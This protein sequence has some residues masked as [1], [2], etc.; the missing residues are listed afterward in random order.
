MGRDN[1]RDR[2]KVCICVK[3]LNEREVMLKMKK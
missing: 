1:K 3:I 2:R